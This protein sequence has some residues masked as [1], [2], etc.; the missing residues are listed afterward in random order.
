MRTKFYVMLGITLIIG[1]LIGWIDSGP[2]WDD[3]GITMAAILGTALVAG[4]L[5]RKYAW[6]WALA[7][8]AWTPLLNTIRHNNYDSLVALAFAFAGA[9]VGVVLRKTAKIMKS[10]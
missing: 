10:W 5:M 6:V 4:I 8:G 7:I 9:Y 3:T 1:F 2:N